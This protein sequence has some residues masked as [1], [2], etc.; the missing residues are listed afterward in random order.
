VCGL[1][2]MASY[3]MC[4]DSNTPLFSICVPILH[5]PPC[6]FFWNS[7]TSW[8]SATQHVGIIPDFHG[9]SAWRHSTRSYGPSGWPWGIKVAE[10][11]SKIACFSSSFQNDPRSIYL[12]NIT[13]FRHFRAFLDG[14]HRC[15]NACSP[16]NRT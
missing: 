14:R 6:L 15:L 2:Y 4:R 8:S 7:S 3:P 12:S 9:I 1:L 13:Y 16:H 5:C 11:G 10:P